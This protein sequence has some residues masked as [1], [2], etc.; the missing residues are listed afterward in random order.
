MQLWV[1]ALTI[2]NTEADALRIS[3]MRMSSSLPALQ[4]D[5]FAGHGEAINFALARNLW[6]AGLIIL[7]TNIRLERRTPE[8]SRGRTLE[9]FRPDKTN[10][11]V[12][13]TLQCSA[14][15][16]R[17]LIEDVHIP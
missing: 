16:K 3:R 8:K 11:P 6:A 17:S 15:T 7:F 14:A 12:Q 1:Y 5:R 10:V 13:N 9:Y 4:V 2:I